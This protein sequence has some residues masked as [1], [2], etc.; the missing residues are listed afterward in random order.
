MKIGLDPASGQFMSWHFDP[1]G[2]HGHGV[3]LRERNHWVVDS[4]GVQGNGADT[5]S[6]NVLTRFGDDELGWRSFDRMVGGKAQPDSPPI[7]L[8]RVTDDQVSRHRT[9]PV[10]QRKEQTMKTRFSIAILSLVA[11]LASGELAEGR[12]FGGYSGSRSFS[13]DKQRS[14]RRRKR[15]VQPVLRRFA[16]RFV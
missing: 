12:G 9:K 5:A 3:W 6:V 11:C 7:R 1:D 15:V 2:G 13:G 8:K 10:D 16:R 4:Q 14:L